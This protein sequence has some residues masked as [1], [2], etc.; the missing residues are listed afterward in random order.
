MER[1]RNLMVGV[2][3]LGGCLAAHA[4]SLPDQ[5]AD[6]SYSY[7]GGG[8]DQ[9][10]GPAVSLSKR[11]GQRY[12]ISGLYERDQI[13]ASEVDLAAPGTSRLDEARQLGRLEFDFRDGATLY[14]AGIS[15]NWGPSSETSLVRAAISQSVFH[16]LT[17]I[18]AGASKGW[19]SKY[20]ILEGSYARDGNY[21]GK[22]NLRSW[23][24][25]VDQIVTPRWRLTYDGGML[26]ESGDLANPN[27]GARFVLND[28]LVATTAEVTPGTRGRYNSALHARYYMARRGVL[29]FGGAYYYDSWG[30]R[31]RSYDVAWQRNFRQD[32]LALDVHT[33]WYSQ[34]KAK[35]YTDLE[36]GLP[37]GDIS[38]DRTLSRHSTI[39]L[40]SSLTWQL[41]WKP[42]LGIR[43]WSTGLNA[44]WL[45]YKYDGFRDT[46][47][48]DVAAGTEPFLSSNGF[49]VQLRLTGAF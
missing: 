32:R 12:A 48:V 41:R 17:T 36:T 6:L 8:G 26:D 5:Q 7:S 25:S 22:A 2:A 34:D 49:F 15:R 47:K 30:I 45:R 18:T 37:S 38:R 3:L 9:L 14:T 29:T 40:G 35:F 33:R 28:G 1:I 42:H 23:W 11:I 13:K 21:A 20:R 31:A 24:L 27:L 39:S 19:T 43:H 4:Q 44:D 16:D 10:S 46:R